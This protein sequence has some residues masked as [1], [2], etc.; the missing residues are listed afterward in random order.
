[1][2]NELLSQR[3]NCQQNQSIMEPQLSGNEAKA[4][5][6][7]REI[8]AYPFSTSPSLWGLGACEQLEYTKYS[9]KGTCTTKHYL[10]AHELSML[11]FTVVLVEYPFYWQDMPV[12]YPK[13]IKSIVDSMPLQNH[14]AL[15]VSIRDNLE[16]IDATWD[17]TLERAGFPIAKLQDTIKTTRLGVI[18]ASNPSFFFSIEE[19]DEHKRNMYKDTKP[20]ET[21]VNFYR[22]L[23]MWLKSIRN[24]DR[25]F[26]LPNQL[27]HE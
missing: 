21:I 11:E 4:I 12:K 14:L 3:F 25:Q 8:Q 16:I 10:L 17:P 9:Q 22:K 7:F 23:D 15:G 19:R 5:D 6:I 24:I 1:M 18:P 13:D 26:S 27:S 20:T 2:K